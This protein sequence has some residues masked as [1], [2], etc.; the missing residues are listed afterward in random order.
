MTRSLPRRQGE[1]GAAALSLLV[2]S[3]ILGLAVLFFMAVPLT[4]ATSKKAKSRNA[5]DAAALASVDYVR[6]GIFQALGVSG[7][8]GSWAS[9][10]GLLDGG[11]SEAQYFAAQNDAT[12]V[13]FQGPTLANGWEAY[14][15]VRGNEQVD[16]QW[17][18]SEAKAKLDL[19]N[20]SVE[21][22][23][24]PEPEPTPTPS[25]TDDPEDPDEPEP[26]PEPTP[27]PEPEQR[28]TCDGGIDFTGLDLTNLPGG[29]VDALFDQSDTRLVE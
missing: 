21:T 15:R 6:E 5:A 23:E 25:E 1:R 9:L 16:G 26:E 17:V 7:W 27:D 28:L 8:T 11:V 24:P 22:I 10:A 13:A 4:E 20:C 29:I 18:Y 2:V 14:V 3:V 19:P 12:V